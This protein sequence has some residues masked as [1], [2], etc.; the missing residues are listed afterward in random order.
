MPDPR[1]VGKEGDEEEKE[2]TLSGV[3]S[4]TSALVNQ[5]VRGSTQDTGASSI[6]HGGSQGLPN[7]RGS[8]RDT[9]RARRVSWD[10]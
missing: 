8:V 6:Q 1:Y 10:R 5:V 4:G 9:N 3:G 7:S 2:E